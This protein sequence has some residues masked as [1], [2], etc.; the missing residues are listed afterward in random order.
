MDEVDNFIKSEQG[1]YYDIFQIN[2][3]FRLNI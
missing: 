3:E 2:F 1:K